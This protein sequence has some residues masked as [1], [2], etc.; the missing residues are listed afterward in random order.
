MD[1]SQLLVAKDMERPRFPDEFFDWVMVKCE[2][3]GASPEAKMFARSGAVL[4]KKFYDELFPLAIFVRHEFS[5]R[6]DV[7]ISPNLGNENFDATIAVN[8]A[9]NQETAFVEITFSKDGYDDSLRMEYLTKHGHVNLTGPVSVSGRR[10][11]TNR[12]IQVE[13]EAANHSTLVEQQLSML[14]VRI[15]SKASKRYGRRHVL[16]AAVDDYFPLREQEDGKLIDEFVRRLLPQLELD[17]D[18]VVI[19]GVAGKIFFSYP[20][21]G[22]RTCDAAL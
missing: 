11:A 12:N 7:R 4:P 17:F 3:L 1:A 13:S 5:G 16:L 19:V 8:G 10:G 9:A 22:S 15:E 14:K 2:E 18:R 21:D 20:L 6:T